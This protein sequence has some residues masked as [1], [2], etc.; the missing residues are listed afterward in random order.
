MS[1]RPPMLAVAIEPAR[2]AAALVDGSGTVLVRDRVTMPSRDVWRSLERLVRRVN[3]A[4]P[5]SVGGFDRVTASCVGPVDEQAGT[6]SPPYVPAWSNFALREHL[7]ELTERPVTVA[8]AGAAAAEAERVIGEATDTRSYLF[9]VADATVDSACIIDG[10]RLRGAHGN[11]GSIAHI[12]VDPDGLACWCGSKGCL[13]PYLSSIAL[14]AEMNRP[15]RRVNPSTIERAGIM[16]GRAIASM[17]ATVDLDTVFVTGGVIDAFGDQLLDVARRELHTR[18]RLPNLD[19]LR[20]VEPVEH[21]GPLL[22]AAALD[23]PAPSDSEPPVSA[24][25]GS[26]PAGSASI[27]SDRPDRN[28]R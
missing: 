6:V 18:T 13:E 3:A 25:A 7:E 19:G 26:E 23:G 16:L 27:R 10:R 15:L 8:S 1:P 2:L 20:L 22:R 5:E 14:E 9:V 11:A 17:C 12:T 28:G 21:I 24:P 4:A